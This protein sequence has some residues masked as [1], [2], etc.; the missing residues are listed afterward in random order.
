MGSTE[1]TFTSRET[2][3]DEI[4]LTV[5]FQITEYSEFKGIHKDHEVQPRSEV[6]IQGLNPQGWCYLAPCSNQ[7]SY[8]Q[9]CQRDIVALLQYSNQGAYLLWRCL[10]LGCDAVAGS[11]SAWK[12]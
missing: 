12:A 5:Y 1:V 2:K 9:G 6:P 8:S 4:V 11:E 7:L 10:Y 3:A